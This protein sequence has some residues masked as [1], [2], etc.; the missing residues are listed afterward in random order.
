M[1]AA[2]SENTPG[3][4]TVCEA[5]QC[6]FP[7]SGYVRGKKKNNPALEYINLV[8]Q[9]WAEVPVRN[10]SISE[11]CREISL[12]LSCRARLG[13]C[14]FHLQHLTPGIGNITRV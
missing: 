13:S 12:V 5:S 10:K 4:K 3:Q 6:N 14:M 11:G 8:G 7:K 9:S 1:S 2:R